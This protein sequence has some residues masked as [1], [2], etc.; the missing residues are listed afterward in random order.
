MSDFIELRT[1]LLTLR[2][3]WWLL[4]LC[5]LLGVGAGYGYSHLQTPIYRATTRLAVAQMVEANTLRF[6]DVETISQQLRTY[7]DL[8]IRRPLLDAVIQELALTESWEQLQARVRAVAQEESQLLQITVDD[9]APAQAQQIAEQ[10]A[11]QLLLRN[12]A[13]QKTIAY[14]EQA[15]FVQTQVAE[16]TQ[17]LQEGQRQL[18]ILR[19]IQ[20]TAIITDTAPPLWA[21]WLSPANGISALD[22]TGERT[23]RLA[24]EIDRLERF[25]IEWDKSYNRWNTILQEIASFKSLT[26]VDPAYVSPAPVSPQRQL[27]TIAAGALGLLLALGFVAFFEGWSDTLKASDD[28]SRFTRVPLLGAVRQIKGKTTR[29]K[30]LLNRDTPTVL[31]DYR[32]LHSKFQLMCT[33]LP[34]RIL[35]TSPNA[36]EGRSLFVANLGIVA[37]QFGYRTLIA[38][39]DWRHPTQHELFQI[40]NEKGLL[41]LLRNPTANTTVPMWSV[42]RLPNLALLTSGGAHAQSIPVATE[43][44]LAVG[45]SQPE[46]LG[47]VLNQLTGHADLILLDSSPLLLSAETVALAG[48]VDG[49]ILVVEPG[50]TKRRALQEALFALEQSHAN[51]IGVVFNRAIVRLDNQFLHA[52]LPAALTRPALESQAA[53]GS[54]DHHHVT[55]SALSPITGDSG[56]GNGTAQDAPTL[57][58]N[59]VAAAAPTSAKTRKRVVLPMRPA[60]KAKDQSH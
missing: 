41:Q 25:M 8:A 60:H 50:K 27:N 56:N 33:K 46:R 15:A 45:W 59:H 4:V 19:T 53:E 51:L 20:G 10:I 34:K 37:A 57:N 1:V 36:E 42:N 22:P 49:V 13:E 52:L 31:N 43:G 35:I 12:A 18:D 28:L 54:L 29:E 47:H 11:Q 7:A 30:L 44:A 23:R 39:A 3:W 58:G 38:D 48:Q 17:Q 55:A 16:A 2:R 24:E 5:T 40:A 14:A 6:S 21:Y 9:P 32:L 26:V